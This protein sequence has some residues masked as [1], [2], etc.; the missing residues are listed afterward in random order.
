[1]FNF[2][3]PKI[4]CSRTKLFSLNLFKIYCNKIGNEKNLLLDTLSNFVQI[5]IQ[6]TFTASSFGKRF[7]DLNFY[8][9]S[10]GTNAKGQAIKQ[11]AHRHT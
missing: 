9:F 6:D 2:L 1:M 4:L 8:Y 3:Y 7:T 10:A 11:Q 5:F